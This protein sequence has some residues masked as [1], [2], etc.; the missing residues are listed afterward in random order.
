MLTFE[1]EKKRTL[2]AIR[3]RLKRIEKGILEKEKAL[4][5]SL[6]AQKIS[7]YGDLLKANFAK[8]KPKLSEITVLD[9]LNENQPL[10]LALD[11]D[12]SPQE[13]LEE[14]YKKSKKLKR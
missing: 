12:L 11:P 2:K 6:N 5:E 3:R 9:W 13:Q 8:L 14:L 7:H 10:T 4:D 1:Q